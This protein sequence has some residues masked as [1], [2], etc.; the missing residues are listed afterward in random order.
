MIEALLNSLWQGAFIVAVAAGVTTFVPQRHAATRYTVWFAALVALAILPITSLI[1]FGDADVAIPSSVVQTTTVASHVTQSAAINTGLWLFLAWLAG[2]MLC[3]GRL[4]LSYRRIFEIVRT[5]SAQP[6]LGRDVYT[7]TMVSIPIAAGIVRPVV[8]VPRDL[9]GTLEPVDLE[10][11]IAHER[12]HIRRGDILGNLI[13]RLFEAA[14]FF[15]PWVY[16]IGRQLVKEREAACDDWAVETVSDPDRYATC[17]A[18]I[19]QRAPRLHTPLLTPSAIGSG[20]MLV[21]RIARLLNGKASQVK[22]NYLVLAAAVALFALLGFAFQT[23][24]SV[25][26]TTPNPLDKKCYADP[27]ALTPAPPEIPDAVAMAHP[28]VTALA[29]VEVSASGQPTN[30]KIV[31]SSG[32]SVIDAATISAATKSTYSP[33]MRDCKKT[34]GQYL[35]R[36]EVSPPGR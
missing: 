25:A 19:A 27:Q 34:K 7:S 31:K 30:A 20:R 28:N 18:R 6:Q 11:V 22:P 36:V 3:A 13:Q 5:S 9:A 29:L 35:F 33:A 2:T 15:N 4:A 26:S 21:A 8:I 17:L 16:V 23:P 24:R 1:S 12:A 32:N 10:S 14:L